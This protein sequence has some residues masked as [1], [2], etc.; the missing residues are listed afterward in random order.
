MTPHPAAADQTAVE[1]DSLDFCYG[2]KQ[3]PVSYTHLAAFFS[4]GEGFH[5]GGDVSDAGIAD[6]L[7]VGADA[8]HNGGG[9]GLFLDVYKRQ[10]SRR[11][12][13]FRLRSTVSSSSARLLRPVTRRGKTMFS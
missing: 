13:P 3:S 2:S 10:S 8:L 11:A 6:P 5:A 4:Q 12:A 1:V 7:F 9:T